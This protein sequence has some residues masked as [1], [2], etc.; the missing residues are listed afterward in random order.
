MICA[1]GAAL[2]VSSPAA[3]NRGAEEFRREIRP[4][5]ETY[6]YDCHADGANKG[7][8]AFDEFPSDAAALEDRELWLRALKNVRAGL[9][10]PPKKSQPGPADKERLE[11]WIKRS[12]FAADPQNPDQIGRAH[13]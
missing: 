7:K 13:V 5:L 1:A 8:V 9:M 10:P 2:G 11:H 12:V 3:E 4:I 6:C